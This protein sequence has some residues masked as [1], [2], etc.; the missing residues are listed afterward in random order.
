MLEHI[1]GL[2]SIVAVAWVGALVADLVDQ[3]AAG[4]EPRRHRVQARAP[5]RHQSG[6]RRR[7]ACSRP[8]PASPPSPACSGP[9]LQALSAFVALGGRLRR[10]AGDRLG[11]E[12]PLL[13]RAHAA[14]ELERPERSC[15]AASASTTSRP[16]TWRTARPIPGRSARCAARSKPAATT[17]ASR[18]RASR[19][20]SQPSRAG[21]CRSGSSRPL[22]TDVGHYLGVLLLF[23]GV[24]GSVLSWSIF[25]SRSIPTSPKAGCCKSTLWTVFF[26]LT[27]IAGVAAWLFVLAQESRRVA[28]EEIAPPD[29][30]ADARNRGA[31]AH[32]R[33]AA[34][35]QGDRRSRQ[36][37]QEPLRRGL[38]PRTAHA[39]QCHPRLRPDCSSATPRIPPHSVDA[40]QGRA[41]QRRASCP[42]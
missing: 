40:D 7:D 30:P 25:R 31:Q 32:R 34:E 5:L 28:E 24:I 33:Q 42:A 12:G 14:A 15:A 17:A 23:G 39:A 13:H 18:R 4:A 19:R 9:T 1:L 6:R 3:Q 27:I 21:S 2:Y 37:G 11:D 26:I 29:R 22:N 36:Q 41:P 8:S 35:G 10:G 38:E 20:R 16:R